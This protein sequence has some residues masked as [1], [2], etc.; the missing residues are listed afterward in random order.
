MAFDQTNR[1]VLFVKKNKK[2]EKQ[3]DYDGNINVDGKDYALAGWK[4]TSQKGAT[5]L[6]LKISEAK[7][8]VNGQQVDS[9]NDF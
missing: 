9:D 5:F 8:V 3:P 7:V 2:N 4:K 1:G 6:S